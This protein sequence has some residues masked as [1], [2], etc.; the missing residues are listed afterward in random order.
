MPLVFLTIA[1][2][3]PAKICRLRCFL[4]VCVKCLYL[5]AFCFGFAEWLFCLAVL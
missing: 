5:T 2:L 4:L 1:Q 3:N